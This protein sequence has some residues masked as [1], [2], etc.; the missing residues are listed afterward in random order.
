M[1]HT[2]SVSSSFL[3]SQ[4]S[5]SWYT[6]IS[7]HQTWPPYYCPSSFLSSLSTSGNAPLP[8]KG[9]IL[10]LKSKKRGPP[11]PCPSTKVTNELLPC[12]FLLKEFQRFGGLCSF[13]LERKI[14]LSSG[15]C[16]WLPWHLQ[17]T[18][19]AMV[20]ARV[21]YAG[22]F[23]HLGWSLVFPKKMYKMQPIYFK[24]WYNSNI[25]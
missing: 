3:M 13:K 14:N 12:Y 23:P 10:W 16:S 17:L 24:I 1:S 9:I 20:S 4:L 2:D 19:W 7:G 6:P 25:Y 21:I 5:H 22:K 18:T 15:T 11:D 8:S